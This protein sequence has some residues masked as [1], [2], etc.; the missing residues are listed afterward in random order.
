MWTLT[1]NNVTRPLE[2]WKI[3]G[4]VRRR[5]SQA[6]DQVTFLVATGFDV[7]EPFAADSEITI[8][9]DGVGW[10]VGR[11]VGLRRDA[12]GS[13]ESI[14]YD[15]AG[16]WWYLDRAVYQ[17][18]WRWYDGSPYTK[19]HAILNQ[20]DQGHPLGTRGQ[21]IEVLQLVS[22][23]ATS[24]FGSAPFQ[25]DGGAIPDINIP[26]DEVR[27]LTC[28]E[29]VRKQ[30]RWM[31]DAVTWFD[32][33][34]SP[35]T[36]RCARRA[37]LDTI[38]ISEADSI[39]GITATPRYDL[40]V[41]VVCLK[42]ERVD[43]LNGQGVLSLH[44]QIAPAGATGD[45]FGALVAT[46]D[47]LGFSSS[48]ASA[49]VQ[50]EEL[51]ETPAAVGEGVTTKDKDAWIKWI[52]A[53]QSWLND[54]AVRI[55]DVVSV[56]R[57]TKHP[58]AHLAKLEL[59]QGQI[60][61]WINGQSWDETASVRLKLM[62]LGTNGIVAEKGETTLA[63]NFIGTTVKSGSY[64]TTTSSQAGEVEPA[65]LAQALYEA[66]SVLE[67][68]GELRTV[69]REIRGRLSVGNRC[70][71][72][73][74]RSEWSDMGAVI[75]EVIES[76][77]TGETVARFGP[78]Q[79]LGPRDLVELLRVGRFRYNYTAPSARSSGSAASSNLSS[80]GTLPR[81]NGDGGAN[82]LQRLV[83]QVGGGKVILDGEHCLGQE[84]SVKEVAVCL[85]G[86]QKRMF[87]IASDPF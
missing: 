36:F 39:S 52:K 75:Q 17:Q 10:F 64:S 16:P 19:S 85:N 67:W 54:P 66:L 1:A 68:E 76:I 28:A 81:Q 3:T 32:Y 74:F 15:V 44:K 37:E 56:R 42:F 41:P 23:R 14:R 22:D 43:S 18:I 58:D 33:S 4:L 61:P 31:P 79:H 65:G 20:T 51:P 13:A 2:A 46:I 35:P 55:V 40:R 73:G 57:E 53:K 45:E 6:V 24:A 7:E 72:L 63:V 50:S 59:L 26:S 25:W 60:P 5:S 69:Q 70:N 48:S 11:V 77:D 38:E 62:T 71:V 87:L 21:I 12:S 86:V 83:V 30:L 29:V 8:Q 84:L 78:P 27:D 9:K 49:T 80:G 34:T 82:V 47:L